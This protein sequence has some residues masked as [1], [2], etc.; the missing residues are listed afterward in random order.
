M[1][2]KYSHVYLD[3]KKEIFQMV[4]VEPDMFFLMI[5]LNLFNEINKKKQKTHP[6]PFNIDKSEGVT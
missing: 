1:I 6:L 5:Y 3:K 4:L 2:K